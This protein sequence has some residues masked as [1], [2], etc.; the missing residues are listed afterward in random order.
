M[1]A[2]KNK[3]EEKP[4]D[5]S[6]NVEELVEAILEDLDEDGLEDAAREGVAA[7]VAK[8]SK[9]ERDD[10]HHELVVF[11]SQR[12]DVVITAL[13]RMIDGMKGKTDD[14]LPEGWS[15]KEVEML[16]EDFQDGKL[17]V[18]ECDED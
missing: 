7:R 18:E 13:M 2:K 3:A 6:V 1:R 10:E 11:P 5:K 12:D 14:Y 9:K 17:T 16:L 8:M 4:A 15:K